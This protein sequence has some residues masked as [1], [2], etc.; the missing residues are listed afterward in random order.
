MHPRRSGVSLLAVVQGRR[1]RP[2][3]RLSIRT[4]QPL[5]H[6]D[7]QQA[8]RGSERRPVPLP[9]VRL[10]PATGREPLKL[11]LPIMHELLELAGMH[12]IALFA[13]LPYRICLRS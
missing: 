9:P 11:G 4:D 6:P 5:A 10:R 7:Q 8:D 12:G 1:H 13:G 2:T 3:R